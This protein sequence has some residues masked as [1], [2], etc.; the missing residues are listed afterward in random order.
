MP[1]KKFKTI[2]S[3]SGLARFLAECSDEPEGEIPTPRE[4]PSPYHFS[5]TVAIY[6]HDSGRLVFWR[7]TRHRHFEVFEL[8][9]EPE[10]TML[11]CSKCGTYAPRDYILDR[12]LP[13]GLELMLCPNGEPHRYQ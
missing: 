12:S 8:T 5:S 1:Y 11:V 3:H 4:I 10:S 7:E 6:R 2:N 9:G 13:K